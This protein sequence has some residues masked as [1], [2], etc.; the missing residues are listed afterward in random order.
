VTAQAVIAKSAIERAE[1]AAPNE[2][3][4]F[5]VALTVPWF[6]EDELAFLRND[7]GME[8][9][10]RTCRVA[11]VGIPARHLLALSEM[12]TVIGVG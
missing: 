12:E 7:L 3:V 5:M 11:R 1:E 2:I 4:R 10:M 6:S 9:F 8:Y